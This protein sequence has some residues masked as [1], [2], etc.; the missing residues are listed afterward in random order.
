M[1][2]VNRDYGCTIVIVTHNDAIRHMAHRV[3]RLRDG[4]LAEDARNQQV[5]AARDL[6]W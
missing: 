6:E 3:L 4:V 5:L 1:E 2:R